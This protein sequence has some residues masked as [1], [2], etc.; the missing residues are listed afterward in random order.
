MLMSIIAFVANAVFYLLL[1]REIYVDRAL[2]PDGG[3]REWHRS[4]VTRLRISGQTWIL[5]LELAFMAVS[6]ISSVLV[7]LGVKAG[8]VKVIQLV[9]LMAVTVMFIIIMIVTANQN[10]RYV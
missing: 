1:N 10:V 7:I 4:A 2:M 9:S 5:Y 6:I 3:Y 8:A